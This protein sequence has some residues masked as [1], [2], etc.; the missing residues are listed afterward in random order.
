MG[1]RNNVDKTLLTPMETLAVKTIETPAAKTESLD[2]S[3]INCWI[4]YFYITIDKV[5]KKYCSGWSIKNNIFKSSRIEKTKSIAVERDCDGLIRCFIA[6][7]EE[8]ATK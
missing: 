6:I 3:F 2:F 5:W 1:K 8:Y 7:V 4:L